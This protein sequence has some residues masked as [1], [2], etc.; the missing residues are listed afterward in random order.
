MTPIERYQHLATFWKQQRQER[1]LE[2]SEASREFEK[3]QNKL[4]AAEIAEQLA[5]EDD[6]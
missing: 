4:V 1:H 5:K 2:W 3:W 6:Q